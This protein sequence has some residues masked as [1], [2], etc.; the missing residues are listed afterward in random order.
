MNKDEI[1]A[2]LQALSRIEGATFN[3]QFVDKNTFIADNLEIINKTL[4]KLL[5]ENDE[6]KKRMRNETKTNTKRA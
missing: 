6:H 2:C 3:E 1:I 5:K 4:I